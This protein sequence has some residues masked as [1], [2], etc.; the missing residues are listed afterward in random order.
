MD[1]MK[2]KFMMK[3]MME[4]MM[5]KS[6]SSMTYSH[7][8]DDKMDKMDNYKMDSHHGSSYKKNDPMMRMNQLMEMFSNSRRSKRQAGQG[9]LD[10]GDRLVEKLNEQKKAMEAK[11]GNMTCVLKQLKCLDKDNNIDVSEMKKDME[12]YTMP[13]PWFA[14]RYEE[15]LDTCHDMATNLPDKIEENS[16]VTG[17]GFGTVNLAQIKSFMKCCSK[18]KTRLC[19]HQDIKKKIETNFGPLEDILGQT[20]LTEY[21]IFPLV[22]Q[23]LHGQEMDYMMGEM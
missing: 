17:E 15:I 22:I 23:L 7:K 19:M 4:D 9:N 13:S 21:Q 3:Q 16:V 20:Q 5:K 18:A 11:V 1:K 2:M 12:Q 6:D 10:L 8:S 14:D